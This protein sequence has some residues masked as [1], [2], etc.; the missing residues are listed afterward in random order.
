MKRHW[1]YQPMESAN[2][3]GLKFLKK[4]KKKNMELGGGVMLEE[5]GD[6]KECDQNIFYEILKEYIK[7]F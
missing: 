5:L 7:I 1:A 2:T 6:K 3:I 4:E